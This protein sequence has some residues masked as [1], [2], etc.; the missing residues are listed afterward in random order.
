MYQ[1]KKGD[2]I[3]TFVKFVAGAQHQG[4]FHLQL[5]SEDVCTEAHIHI[6]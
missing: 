6:F 1:L 3:N 5:Q 4:N 2:Q